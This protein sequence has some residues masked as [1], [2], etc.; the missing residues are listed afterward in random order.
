MLCLCRHVAKVGTLPNGKTV[1]VD[2]LL[3]KVDFVFVWFADHR[4]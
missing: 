3:V 2:G 1:L 4:V